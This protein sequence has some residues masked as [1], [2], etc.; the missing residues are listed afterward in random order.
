MMLQQILNAQ[1]LHN[2]I[3][4]RIGTL[5]NLSFTIHLETQLTLLDPWNQSNH[6]QNA[7]YDDCP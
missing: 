3:R 7:R 1:R 2:A 6:K 5:H 4:L